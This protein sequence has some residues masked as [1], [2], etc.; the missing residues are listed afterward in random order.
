MVISAILLLL[1]FLPISA[2]LLLSIDNI[3]NYII[4]RAAN[5]ASD[6]L[7]SRVTIG[8]ID[9][10]LLSKVHVYDF[11]V[12]DPECDTLLYVHKAEAHIASLDI[13]NDGL[14]L[15]NVKVDRAEFNLR[16]MDS[17]ELNIRPIVQK[18]TRPNAKNNF[19]MYISDAEVANSRFR[20]ER[21]V[22]RN[23]EY[24]IDYY[25]MEIG[26][27][28][29][30]LE[31]FAVERSVVSSKVKDLSARERSGF[32][33]DNLSIFFLVDKGVIRFNDLTVKTKESYIN[34]PEFVIE[35]KDWLEYKDYINL[36]NMRGHV[37]NS[38]LST[39]DLGFFAPGVRKWDLAVCEASGEFEGV[40]RDFVATLHH[41][42]IGSNTIVKGDAHI[43]GMPDWRESE[44]IV[45]IKEL[46][47]SSSDV[48]LFMRNVT[49]RE[50]H[51][52]V[53]SI[54]KSLATADVRG[55]FG[56]KLH[57]FR[58]V[59]NVT[60]GQGH[61]SADVT[62]NRAGSRHILSGSVIT[63]NL[64]LGNILEVKKLGTVDSHISANANIGSSG[65]IS[66]IDIKVDD[67]GVGR[68]RLHNI[69]AQGSIDGKRYEA[70]VQ[71]SDENLLFDLNS[72]ID[73]DAHLPSYEV[74][75][76]LRNADLHNLGINK[77]DSI[78]QLSL[79]MGVDLD[80]HNFDDMDGTVSVANMRYA[81]PRGELESDRISAVI[82]GDEEMKN[83]EIESD[84]ADI[85][86]QSRANYREVADYLFNALKRYVPLLYDTKTTTTNSE[87]SST[88]LSPYDYSMFMVHTHEELNNLL[89]AVAEGMLCAP[90]T[91]LSMV[92][93]PQNN[94]IAVQLGS[95]ALEY[96]GVILA[97]ANLDIKNDRDSLLLWINSEAI[98]LGARRLM[99]NF[100]IT[101]MAHQNQINLSADFKDSDNKQSGLLSMS[102]KFSRN[103]KTNRRSMHIDVSPSHFTTK[104]Q[105]WE[106]YAGGVDIDSS[107]IHI[108]QLHIARPEQQLVIDGVAS[109]DR[110]DS[111]SLYL[112]NFDLSPLSALISRWGYNVAASSYGYATVHSALHNPQIDARID[113]N[114][115]EVNGIKAPPQLLTSNWDFER[116]RARV[117]IRDCKSL[118]TVI[119]GY[120][121]PQGNR[122]YAEANVRGVEMSLLQ[123]FLKGIISDI[124]GTASATANIRGEGR[125]AKLQG[126]AVVDS[127]DVHVDY[128]NTRYRAPRGELTIKDNHFI[129]DRIPVYDMEGNQG[130]YSMDISLEHLSNITYNIDIDAK[131]MLVFDTNAKQNDL[132]YGHVYASGTASFRG[133]KRGMKMEI[134]GSSAPNSKFYMPLS[135]KEDVSY[136]DF[137][138]FK[139]P[140][141]EGKDT[142]RFLTRRMM[143]HERRNRPVNTSEGIMDMD[144]S[145]NILP[146]VEVQLV[147]DPTVGDIIKGKGSGQL[148]MHIVPK[149]NIFEMSGDYTITEGTYL[150]TLQNVIN[151]LFTVKP[152]S[153]IQWTGDPL[154]A[155]LNI[156]AVYSTKASLKPLIGNSTQGADIAR[157]VPVNCYIELTGALMS[158]EVN[159]DV[160]VTNV[161]PEIQTIVNSALND[162]QAIATQMFW[163]LA[164]NTFSAE[165]TGSMG[166]SLSATTGFELLSNQLSNWLSGDNY[167][168]VL[169]Y[170]PRTELTG[171]EVDFGFSKSL[172]NNRLIIEVEGGYLSDAASRATQNASNFVAEG[173]ITWLI[174]P[175][176]AFR[177]KGFT[178]TIDRYGENQGMQE[179]GIGLYYGES[180]NTFRDLGRSIRNRFTNPERK[181]R[182][183]ERRE[184]K[185]QKRDSLLNVKLGRDTIKFDETL[186]LETNKN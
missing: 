171:D 6:Y 74:M 79:L 91:E 22:H 26:N 133:D 7:D 119:R 175:D 72:I 86:F 144:I 41:A 80:G 114:D 156:D 150:F 132:F 159:F 27:V 63:D 3:Q 167:N 65:I 108:N 59:G 141:V 123:P 14:R 29:A 163:L 21:L 102:A 146:N 83:I 184:A 130:H 98:Y 50:P 135:G 125:M 131:D 126:S 18:L 153:T 33:I 55:T 95:E 172:L 88:T 35:G 19:R 168:I 84:F 51:S 105:Q 185:Q 78:S 103:A 142:S 93:S 176:G 104:T 97:D 99:P 112:D 155:E 183:R 145:L 62:M 20:Y 16:E 164:A 134:E 96:K 15:K 124:H 76:N 42:Q 158:P 152:G 32:E 109:R 67:I 5:F 34:V 48:E 40:V 173:F 110:G 111:I 70:N 23:P 138:R 11:Y 149:A 122:Y 46:H 118:D 52:K 12:E 154:G 180:F 30:K 136:A 8:R 139:E 162:Q 94:H 31:D 129:A 54:I 47:T 157:A 166:A 44:Y 69:K 127:I 107:R 56:G 181:Q 85:Q 60:T 116:N 66:N 10:D 121:Q 115:I 43:I 68:N 36:V 160:E 13:I 113:L 106:L 101:G 24:G 45:G 165:D 25:D 37:V 169:R 89:D 143:A 71:S 87:S 177:L 28:S 90:D 57:S 1:I 178:Q 170:R 179:S 92:F 49:G 38:S 186:E 148:A 73:L 137:V 147:I 117:I 2:T 39:N 100:N 64:H 82:R 120:Y 58:A 61:I 128:T 9:I 140:V 81:Y 174:D 77:R 182:R 151:K 75:L 4:R 53:N 161:A 17:G